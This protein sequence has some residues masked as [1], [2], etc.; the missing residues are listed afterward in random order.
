MEIGYGLK[1]GLAAS[2]YDICGVF[3]VWFLCFSLVVQRGSCS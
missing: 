2:W 1:L 3:V